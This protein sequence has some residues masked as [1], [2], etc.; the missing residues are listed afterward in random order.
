MRRDLWV[1]RTSI[2]LALIVVVAIAVILML[3]KGGQPG[4]GWLFSSVKLKDVGVVIWVVAPV[5]VL[6][7]LCAWWRPSRVIAG[8]GLVF[9]ATAV[10][11]IALGTLVG[12]LTWHDRPYPQNQVTYLGMFFSFLG[13]SC[14]C[15]AYGL[16]GAGVWVVRFVRRR[17]LAARVVADGG[18]S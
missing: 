8:V 18:T 15:F 14:V 5:A 2:E 13:A 17:H 11:M 3:D 7:G 1:L 9:L 4:D 12:Y 16:L 6:A 10:G